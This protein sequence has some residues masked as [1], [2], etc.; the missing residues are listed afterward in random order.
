MSTNTENARQLLSGQGSLLVSDEDGVPQLKVRLND[1][2]K[3]RFGANLEIVAEM[4]TQENSHANIDI[5][6]NSEADSDS[7]MENNN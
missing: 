6:T 1:E 3:T 7:E 4:Q 2:E 5:Q